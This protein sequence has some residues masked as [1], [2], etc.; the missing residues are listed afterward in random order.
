MPRLQSAENVDRVYREHGYVR[1]CF[2]KR[3]F[4]VLRLLCAFFVW[5]VPGCGKKPVE[6]YPPGVVRIT[7]LSAADDS[8]QP[9]LYWSP[10]ASEPVPLLVALHTWSNDY[11]QA[12]EEALYAKWCQKA[13]WAFVHPDF[14]G[15]NHRTEAMGSDLVVADILSAVDFAKSY[16]NIDEE[17][18]YCVGVSGGGHAALLMAARAPKVW[19]GVS[20]WCGISD[21]AAWHRECTQA[22]R[23]KYANNIETALGGRPDVT[24][25][26]AEAA[27]RSPV[28][29]FSKLQPN[30]LPNLDINHGIRDGRDGSVPFT[31][32]LFAWNQCVTKEDAI[33]ESL[34]S[35]FY[36]THSVGEELQLMNQVFDTNK[37]LMRSNLPVFQ[38]AAGKARVT[39]FDG[40]HE[41]NHYAALNWLAA[42]R[43][44]QPPVWEFSESLSLE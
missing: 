38:R 8:Q 40:A 28:Y 43:R 23:N 31:H 37:S 39:I 1:H 35:A 26:A 6:G 44:Q 18:V 22:G 9:A 11:A 13:G 15:A 29:W 36:K 14:R 10:D 24:E 5:C 27:R 20:A 19:A 7:Y 4:A 12:G 21:I 2:R 30:S 41:I 16:D 34:I 42:Q 17:R 3:E 33:P 32:S 25:R